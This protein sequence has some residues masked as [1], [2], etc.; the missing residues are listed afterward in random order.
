L[1]EIKNKKGLQKLIGYIYWFRPFIK[2]LSLKISSITD[3]TKAKN[4]DYRLNSEE[5]KVVDD[6]FN[7]IKTQCLLNYPDFNEYF[8]LRTDA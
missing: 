8:E 7:E 2:D 4:K 3:K 6:I 1:L 5:R